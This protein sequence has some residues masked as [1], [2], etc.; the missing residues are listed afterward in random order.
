M[1]HRHHASSSCIMRQPWH[2][3][4]HHEATMALAMALGS[5]HGTGTGTGTGRAGRGRFALCVV[6]TAPACA[7][8]PF[9]SP[10]SSPPGPAWGIRGRTASHA[11]SRWNRRM[12]PSQRPHGNPG[13]T[14]PYTLRGQPR[15][16]NA[17]IERRS[18]HYWL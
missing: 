17:P 11:L 16:S 3:H 7:S 6:F 14:V 8:S 10:H 12:H 15:M 13:L 9:R 4:W 5:N 2:W 1:H 18:T